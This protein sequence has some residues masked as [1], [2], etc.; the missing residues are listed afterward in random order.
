MKLECLM[1]F[2]L[3]QSLLSFHGDY[4]LDYSC[5]VFISVHEAILMLLILS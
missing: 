1:G 3:E 5:F 4:P 2:I